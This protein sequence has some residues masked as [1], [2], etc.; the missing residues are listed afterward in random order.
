MTVASYNR[1]LWL[2]LILLRCIQLHAIDRDQKLAGLYHTAWDFQDGAPA[3]IRALAQ[4]TDGFLWL[5]S[6][7]GLWMNV[8]SN[9]LLAAI[10]LLQPS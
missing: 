10:M 7:T 9:P 5:G 2:L 8:D 3:E 1:S 4:T 6:A